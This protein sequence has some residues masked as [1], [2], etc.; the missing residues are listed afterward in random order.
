MVVGYHFG[1]LQDDFS[2]FW[3]RCITNIKTLVDDRFPPHVSYNPSWFSRI[4][5]D[6]RNTDKGIPI[7]NHIPLVQF[8]VLN[9]PDYT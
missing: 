6:A 7:D 2:S 1:N 9:W 5:A 8:Q 4:T 3:S